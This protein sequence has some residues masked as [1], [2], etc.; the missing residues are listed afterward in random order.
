ML[1]LPIV[2]IGLVGRL[3]GLRKG[4]EV[5]LAQLARA[6]AI[7]EFSPTR[8]DIILHPAI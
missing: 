7:E 3:V 5:H 6:E 1:K 4:R 8:V 2:A